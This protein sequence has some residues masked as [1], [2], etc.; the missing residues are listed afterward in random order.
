MK[1]LNNSELKV[2]ANRIQEKL[3][4]EAAI[5][6][7][8]KDAQSDKDNL[9]DAQLALRQIKRLGE[10]AKSIIKT[11]HYCIKIEELT[12][13]H[14]LKSMRT[15]QEKIRVPSYYHNQEVLDA[16]IIGQISS[17]DIEALCNSVAQQFILKP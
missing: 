8:E 7:K 5:A 4:K 16:L 6:Q 13:E 17:P 10:V 14:V 3:K 11:R 1:K 9:K 2:L 15:T 12:L